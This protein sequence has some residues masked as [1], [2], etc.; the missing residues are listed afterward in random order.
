[1]SA[2][3]V[4]RGTIYIT[5]QNILTSAMGI[6]FYIVA[7]RVLTPSD[8]GVIASLQFATAIYTTIAILS[9]QTAATKYMSEE[10]G[11]GRSAVAAAV[12]LQTL[13]IVVVSSFCILCLSIL[14][15]PML[16]ESLLG[17]S[18]GSLVFAIAFLSA[19]FGIVKQMYVSFLQGVQRLDLFAKIHIVTVLVSSGLAVV[20]VILGYG[21]IGV[22]LAWLA[23][24]VVGF[25][26]SAFL[27]QKCLPEASVNGY[28]IS[29]LFRF[30][31]PLLLLGLVGLVANWS[32]RMIFLAVT[33]SLSELGIYDLA[34]R[35]S[36]TLSI[37][38]YA[39]GIAV[40]PAFSE[41]YGRSGKEGMSKAVELSTR[42]LAYLIF[43]AA[44]GL[45]AISETSI[46]FLFGQEYA[47]A[48]TPLGV[49][50]VAYI[51]TAYNVIFITALQAIGETQVFIRIGFATMIT[52]TSLVTILSSY[53]GILGPTVA[54]TA[55]QFVGFAYPLYE[56]SR[57]MD[58][59]I[60]TRAAGKAFLAS[61]LM[62][63]PIRLLDGL[64]M[65]LIV[66][67][68]RFL[69][70]VLFGVLLY[71]VLGI[72]LRLLERRDV[73]LLR[74]VLPRKLSPVIDL[75]EGIVV[76]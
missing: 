48:G 40:L 59:E 16:A 44:V 76:R 66:T 71:C 75:L 18:S 72:L 47:K 2:A 26:L 34:V 24:Q 41:L 5:V 6:L 57:R 60:D 33:G 73:E 7:A 28:P 63:F 13:K 42:Y 10:I 69:L 51:M 45:S 4:A 9:L 61:A 22:V 38:P 29:R 50:S 74:Q 36:M 55:M 12:A 62:A 58:V 3:R 43:P 17:V 49:L 52:Q 35:G 8:I 68:Y 32:D 65:D 15:S 54:R 31:M 19:F 11:R 30:A 25:L 46:I 14:F 64:L 39:I 1:M 67:P 27:Y 53:L 23:S 70:D 20:A 56:L 37:I 21:L